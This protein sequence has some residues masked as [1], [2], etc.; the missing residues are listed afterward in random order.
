ML[1]SGAK[2]NVNKAVIDE[3]KGLFYD[4]DISLLRKS[5][6]GKPQMEN[7]FYIIEIEKDL[8]KYLTVNQEVLGQEKTKKIRM[9]LRQPPPNF[10]AP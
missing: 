6:R 10:L 1:K 9:V 8:K 2:E 7:M 3:G 5:L 4:F